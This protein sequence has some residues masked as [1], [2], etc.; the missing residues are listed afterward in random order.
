MAKKIKMKTGSE[1]EIAEGEQE[2]VE[3]GEIKTEDQSADQNEGDIF[4]QPGQLVADVFETDKDFV[5]LA[6][7]AGVQIK[8]L[9]ISVEKEMMVIKGNRLNP[10]V[11]HEKK[12]FYQECYFGPFSR[13]IILPDNIH[14]EKASAQMDRGL[15]I[16][17]FPKKEPQDSKIDIKTS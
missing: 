7:I 8:D 6:T 15:L 4:A 1:T 14:T 5:V 13:K 12:Y 2:I 9:D 3:G 10:H 11:D 16:V 17:T